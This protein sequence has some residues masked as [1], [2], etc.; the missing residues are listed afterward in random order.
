M[1]IYY[2]LIKGLAV[3]FEFKYKPYKVNNVYEICY[4]LLNAIRVDYV[5]GI[6]KIVRYH[7]VCF[8]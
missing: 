5:Y 6:L 7:V 8:G 3:V 1:L 4:R 2:L